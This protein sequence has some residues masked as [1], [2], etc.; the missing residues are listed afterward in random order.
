MTDHI[1]ALL[2]TGNVWVKH[3]DAPG[4]GALRERIGVQIADNRRTTHLELQGN[5]SLRE[6][7]CVKRSDIIIARESA[8]AVPGGRSG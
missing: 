1:P 4:L 3:T 5:M 6:V 2:P 8:P 7:L